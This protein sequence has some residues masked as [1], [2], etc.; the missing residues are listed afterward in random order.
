MH[1]ST[2]AAMVRSAPKN[3]VLLLEDIDAAFA[4]ESRENNYK[5]TFSGVLN[6][7]GIFCELILRRNCFSRRDNF[8][9]DHKSHRKIR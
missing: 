5:V 4:N 6:A 1:D 2:F 9:D 8:H 3:S 7:I